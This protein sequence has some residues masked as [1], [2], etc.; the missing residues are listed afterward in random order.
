M[1]V[2]QPANAAG[3]RRGARLNAR[4]AIV[5][6]LIRNNFLRRLGILHPVLDVFAERFLVALQ[7]HE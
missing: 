7:S 4:V 1:E 2:L 6:I 5:K 3:D